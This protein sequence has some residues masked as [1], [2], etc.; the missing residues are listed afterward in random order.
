MASIIRLDTIQSTTGNTAATINAA[1]NLLSSGSV[2][3]VVQTNL[4]SR[5]SQT[6][7]PSTVTDI[8][9]LS[10]SITPKGVNSKIMVFVRWFGEWG[11]AGSPYNSVWGLKRNG[12]RVG[13][14]TDPGAT[15]MTALTGTGMTYDGSDAASTPEIMSFFYLDSPATN[16]TITYQVFTLCDQASQTIYTNR[17]VGYANQ[18]TGYELGTSSIVLM[19]IAQ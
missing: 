15:V 19:E 10:C 13:E 7:N 8:T 4:T 3:Q 5:I 14:Q 6:V 1:G 18:V 2:V 9:G 17:T 16:T 11:N 12:T